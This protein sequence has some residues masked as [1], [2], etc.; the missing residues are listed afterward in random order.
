[1]KQKLFKFKLT[2]YDGVAN[3]SYVILL[4]KRQWNEIYGTKCPKNVHIAKIHTYYLS[5]EDL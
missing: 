3:S 2:D 5:T 4:I 1:M